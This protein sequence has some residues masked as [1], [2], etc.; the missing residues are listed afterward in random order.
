MLQ[1]F[2]H[3]FFM[4]RCGSLHAANR[5]LLIEW[6]SQYSQVACQLIGRIAI[7]KS[8]RKYNGEDSCKME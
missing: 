5:K 8:C 3:N 2:S 1:A 7:E 6:I 4:V